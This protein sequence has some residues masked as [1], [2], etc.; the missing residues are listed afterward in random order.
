[1]AFDEQGQA[2]TLERRREVIGR[3]YRILVDEEGWD[4]GDVVFDANVFAVATGLPEHK[5]YAID[6]IETCRF[7][8]KPSAIGSK[9]KNSFARE[10]PGCSSSA[11]RA[12][13][14]TSP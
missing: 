1:M 4:P 2:D 10:R 3:A 7:P 6:F 5:R 14:T 12:R 9:S 13:L 11:S 8:A